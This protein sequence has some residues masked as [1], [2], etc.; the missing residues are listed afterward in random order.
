MPKVEEQNI[1]LP[2]DQ[3][4]GNA[5][6]EDLSAVLMPYLGTNDRTLLAS[7]SSL[8]VSTVTQL[9]YKRIGITKSNAHILDDALALA[10]VNCKKSI[11]HAQMTLELLNGFTHE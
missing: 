1:T 9:L 5:I 11:E 7:M 3:V 8:G 10:K 6:T 2:K 4:I